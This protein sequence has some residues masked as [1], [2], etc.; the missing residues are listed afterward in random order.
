M[1]PKEKKSKSAINDTHNAFA[2]AAR[3]AFSVTL[4]EIAERN[5]KVQENDNFIYGN[6]LETSLDIPVGHDFT[7]VNWLRRTV[8]IHRSQ[9]MGKGFA[10]DSTY[11]ITDPSEAGDDQDQ[12]QRIKIENDQN[13]SF[14]QIRRELV[15][16][17]FEDNGGDAFWSIAAENASAVGDTIVKAWYDDEAKKYTIQQVEMIDGIYVLWSEDDYRNFDAIAYVHQISKQQAIDL[18]D[19]P[20]EVQTSPL[21]APLDLMVTTGAGNSNVSNQPMVTVMEVTGK[22]PGWRVTTA[23]TLEKCKYGQETELNAIIVGNTVYQLIYEDKYLP[24]YYIFPNKRARRRPWGVPDIT[25]SAIQINLTYIEALSDWRTVA[26]KVNFPKFKAYGF[27]PGIQV[28]KPAPRTVELLPLADGQDIQPITMGQSASIAQGDFANQL[29]EMQNQF[30]REVGISRQLFDMPDATGNSNPALITTMKSVSD[31]TNAKRE[32][33]EPIIKQLCEDALRKVAL[34]NNDIKEVVDVESDWSIRISWPSAL[35]ADDPSFNS[36]KLNQ[37]N[38][39]LL[40]VASYL[41]DMGYDKSELDRI[42]DEMEDP[43]TAAIHGHMLGE[44]ASA[45]ISPPGPPAPKVSYSIRGDMSPEQQ[46]NLAASNPQIANGP[47]PITTSPQGN[48][49][50]TATDNLLNQGDIEGNNPTGGLPI[51][52]EAPAPGPQSPELVNGSAD[53][54]EGKGMISMPGSGAT[55]TSA[56]GKMKQMQQRNGG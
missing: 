47:F 9:F 29:N 46:A 51:N 8:E 6:G 3:T 17:I 45:K 41:D 28:P 11:E 24:T 54:A 2:N 1:E 52:H 22:I 32:L 23:G 39:G 15:N 42:R 30:V 55:A 50:R 44:L 26:S 7:P 31:I 56:G 12:R 4:S 21:G 27:P 48:S 40:S 35:N 25:P 18:Y 34:W 33:W 37:F 53:N 19:V 49:G 10:V 43:V 5:K 14:A 13:K 20:E 38:T 36:M 16:S